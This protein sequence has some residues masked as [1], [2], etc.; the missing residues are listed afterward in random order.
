MVRVQSRSF[1]R[2]AHRLL[3]GAHLTRRKDVLT[4]FASQLQVSVVDHHLALTLILRL[5]DDRRWKQVFLVIVLLN[6]VQ[7]TCQL[8]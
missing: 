2:S 4:D 3:H 7:H 1:G 8:L 6:L 5:V